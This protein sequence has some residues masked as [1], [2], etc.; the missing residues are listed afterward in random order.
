MLIIV[1]DGYIRVVYSVLSNFISLKILHNKKLKQEKNYISFRNG[2][3]FPLKY[4][5][6]RAVH[7]RT[8]CFSTSGFLSIRHAIPPYVSPWFI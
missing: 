4:V 5:F 3:L 8:Y 2:L 6:C 1:K 7:M